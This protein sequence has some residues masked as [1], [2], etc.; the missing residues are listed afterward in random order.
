[1]ACI[2]IVHGVPSIYKQNP[3]ER[4]TMNNN[5]AP[6]YEVAKEYIDGL[7]PFYNIFAAGGFA[8]LNESE[9]RIYEHNLNE[10]FRIFGDVY[11]G[12]AVII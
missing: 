12:K 5:T 9:R 6:A 7:R 11:Q 1:M 10:Y 3:R 4:E 2:V 8:N